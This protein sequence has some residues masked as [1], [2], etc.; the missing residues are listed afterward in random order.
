MAGKIESTPNG[1]AQT[2]DSFIV[3]FKRRRL[4][5]LQPKGRHLAR[6]QH[7]QQICC[8][9]WPWVDGHPVKRY[10]PWSIDRLPM[11]SP[12]KSLIFALA[13]K[14]GD[15]ESPLS[16]RESVNR[17]NCSSQKEIEDTVLAFGKTTIGK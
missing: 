10:R 5:S 3:A 7:I 14:A 16:N 11:R 13:M 1:I 12:T 6:H 9:G 8:R 15:R 4:E 2:F 17:Q